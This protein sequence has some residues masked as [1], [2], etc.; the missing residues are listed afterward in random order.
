GA[1]PPSQVREPAGRWSRTHADDRRNAPPGTAP[2]AACIRPVISGPSARLRPRMGPLAAVERF[3]ERLFE[4]QAARLF[5]TGI[6]PIQVQRRL[7]RAME[8]TRIR[9]GAPPGG[10]GARAGP[11]SDWSAEEEA[12]PAGDDRD[13]EDAANAA[14]RDRPSGAGSAAPPVAS[15]FPGGARSSD[16]TA[17]FVVPSSE[18]PRA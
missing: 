6:R 14:G 4:R 1:A 9:D 16:Q 11:A 2:Q 18:G 5:K 17:V 12:G 13:V 8:G 15:P 3:L 10:R 7:E